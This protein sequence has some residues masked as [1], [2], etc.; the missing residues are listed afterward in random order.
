MNTTYTVKHIQKGLTL[1]A[2]GRFAGHVGM[3]LWNDL[4]GRALWQLDMQGENVHDETPET[5]TRVL[6]WIPAVSPALSRFIKIQVGSP[7]KHG[8][9]IEAAD[10][11]MQMLTRTL[12]KWML[13][14]EKDNVPVWRADPEKYEATLDD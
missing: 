4:G 12:A 2:H 10:D 3:R 7:E 14:M 5:V 9:A 13:S 6:R 11:K 8:A 1:F